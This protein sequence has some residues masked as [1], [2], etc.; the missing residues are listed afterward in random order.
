MRIQPADLGCGRR[1]DLDGRAARSAGALDG[2]FRSQLPQTP[3]DLCSQV[4]AHV[5]EL[6]GEGT[7]SYG[8]LQR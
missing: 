6:I 5:L 2:V 3:I 8:M 4:L 7:S 1:G